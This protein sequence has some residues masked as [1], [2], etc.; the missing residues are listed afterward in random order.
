MIARKETRLRRPYRSLRK[1][2]S[3]ERRRKTMQSSLTSKQ[4][5]S[6][7]ALPEM[8]DLRAAGSLAASLLSA[9]GSPL[10]L[11]GSNVK[12]IGAQCMQ[13]IVSAHLTWERDGMSLMVVKA[14]KELMESFRAAGLG[15]EGFM[16]EGQTR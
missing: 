13:L 6:S 1:L 2:R 3:K 14:S 16:E 5:G 4:G 8:M 12:K 9:Q 7:L 15:D 10:V 11:D